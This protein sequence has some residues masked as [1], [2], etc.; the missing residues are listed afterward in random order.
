[1]LPRCL[2]DHLQS[3]CY[4][5]NVRELRQLVRSIVVRHAPGSGMITVGDVPPEARPIGQPSQGAH[6]LECAIANLLATGATLKDIERRAKEAAIRLAIAR[7]D[8]D[9]NGAARSLDVTPRT[10]LN[11]RGSESD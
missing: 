5:G 1:V 8:G 11:H 2:L 3:R 9:R 6:Q 7:H 10:L 4:P